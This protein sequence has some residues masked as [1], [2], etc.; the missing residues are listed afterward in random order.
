MAAVPRAITGFSLDPEGHWV[1]RLTCGHGQHVRHRPPW[2]MR[3]WVLTDEG[4]REHLGLELGCVRC[5]MPELPAAATPYKVLGPFTEATIPAGLLRNHTLK[6]GVWGRIAV[7]EGALRYVIERDPDV[8]FLL[9]P[10][11]PGIVMPEE[12]H[13]VEPTGPVRFQ[14]ELSR[15]G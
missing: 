13:R 8:P 5:S 10:G 6:A 14:V 9:V 1:A 12:P 4:R 11:E 7:L 2:E 15:K 3:P